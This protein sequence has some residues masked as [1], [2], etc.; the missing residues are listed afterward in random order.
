MLYFL[1]IS[2]ILIISTILILEVYVSD[3]RSSMAQ[4]R[5]NNFVTLALRLWSNLAEKIDY[6]HNIKNK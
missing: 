1:L 2:F 6:E 5:H 4:E 3:L